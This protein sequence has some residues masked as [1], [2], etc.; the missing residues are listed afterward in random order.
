MWDYARHPGTTPLQ[1]ARW[2]G[3]L[4]VVSPWLGPDHS[5]LQ[6]PGGTQSSPPYRATLSASW[7]LVA[8]ILSF[9]GNAFTPSTHSH[10]CTHNHKALLRPLCPRKCLKDLRRVRKLPRSNQMLL[11]SHKNRSP[12]ALAWPTVKQALEG[13]LSHQ[14]RARHPC[15]LS[16][17]EQD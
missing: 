5:V 15:G 12:A 13:E 10:T 14:R 2:Q 1:S 16:T 6:R 7:W 11:F 4:G 8:F 17:R 3:K 9:R